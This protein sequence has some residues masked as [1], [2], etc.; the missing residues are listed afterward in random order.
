MQVCPAGA[1]FLKAHDTSGAAKSA[2]NMAA[3]LIEAIE[4]AGAAHVVQVVT[5]S[6]AN[7]KAAGSL[8][9]QK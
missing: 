9:M 2:A 6:A 8:I 4:Q 3:Y 5:D 7:C 1:V